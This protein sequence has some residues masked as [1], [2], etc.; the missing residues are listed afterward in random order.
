MVDNFTYTVTDELNDTA[1]GTVNVTVGNPDPGPAAGP[2][3]ISVNLGQTVDLSAPIL[4]QVTPGLVG[5]TERILQLG[6]NPVTDDLILLPNGDLGYTASSNVL[7]IQPNSSAVDGFSYFVIDQVGDVAENTVNLTINNPDP[8]P[9]AGTVTATAYLGQSVDLTSAILAQIKPGLIGDTETITAV[10]TIFSAGVVRLTSGDLTYKDSLQEGT[11]HDDFT[12]TVTDQWGDQ[13]TGTVNMTVNP[14]PGPTAGT[15]TAAA[16]LGQTVDLT[17]AILAQVAPGLPGDTE[18]ITSISQGTLGVDTLFPDGDLT[19]TPVSFLHLPANGSETE[20]LRYTVTDEYGDTASGAVNVTVSNPVADPGP[21]AGNVAA[22]VDLGQTVDLTSFIVAQIKPG[23]P[24]DTETI[25]AF[26]PTSADGVVTL[27]SGELIYTTPSNGLGIQ[28]GSSAM[29]TFSYTI[30][31]QHNDTANGTV[32]VTVTNPVVANNG[33]VT[34]GRQQTTDLSSTIY[35]LFPGNEALIGVGALYGTAQFLTED[36]GLP[37]AIYT[38]P[39]GQLGSDQ[40]SYKVQDQYGNTATGDL[41]V[42][43]DP[44]PT[45]GNVTVTA[46]LGQTVDLTAAILAQDTPGLPGDITLITSVG[47]D[48]CRRRAE[49]HQHISAVRCDHRSDLHHT[50]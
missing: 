34:V 5:D 2:V 33:S 45:A 22:T 30:T 16:N 36:N 39:A 10:G 21:T 49:A 6:S 17:A 23:L 32:D 29:D 28:P 13:A 9:T 12:Y 14:D 3:A 46:N 18:T 48:Q 1:T 24:G 20:S 26:G 19:Y 35:R 47:D 15:V 44:G 37:G 25:T 43:I 40:V 38:P 8:G 7:R 42:T 41:A 31:D 4:A 50:Q 11:T 27:N